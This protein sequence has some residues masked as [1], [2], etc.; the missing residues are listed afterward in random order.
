[1]MREGEILIA[2]EISDRVGISGATGQNE[3]AQSGT[4]RISAAV[5]VEINGER[6]YFGM[7]AVDP[8]RRGTGLGRFM[9][10]AAENYCRQRGCLFMDIDV[11]S[12]RQELPPFYRKLGYVETGT[13]EFHPSRPLRPGIECHCIKMEKAL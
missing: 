11:L 9:V 8:V 5:Y 6:G 13:E 10:E 4:D 3:N 2:E 7:L 12:L 1:M